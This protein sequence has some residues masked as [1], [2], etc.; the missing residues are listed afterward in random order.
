MKFRT[1]LIDDEPLA[2]GRLKRLLGLYEDF[3]IVAEAQNGLE[4][5]EL[6]ENL[7]PDLIFLDIEMPLMNGFEMLAALQ[8]VPRVVF[9]TAYDQ[10]ALKAFEENSVDYL[11]KPIEQDRLDKTVAKLRAFKQSNMPQGLIEQ[12]IHQLNPKKEM[13]SISVKTGDKIIFLS[14][15]EIS[16]F[17][18]D[19]KYVFVNTLDGNQYLISQTLQGLEEKLPDGFVRISRSAIVQQGAIKEMEKYFSGKYLVKMNDAK[20]SKLESGS[21]YAENLKNLLSF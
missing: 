4:G 2:I 16:Y 14:L 12:L 1:I 15:K 21:T 5:K 19:G 10:Y 8:Y 13:S 11:L 17:M 9:S 18:A 6:I 3:D 7:K 20:Q